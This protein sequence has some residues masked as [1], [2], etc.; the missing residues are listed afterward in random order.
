[1]AQRVEVV[2]YRPEWERLYQTESG[3]LRDILQGQLISVHHIG[4]TAVPGLAAKPVI[5]ILA[6]VKEI[7]A[8]DAYS[9]AFEAEGYECMGE[10]GI[11]GRRYFRKGGD[12]RTHQIHMFAQGSR[13]GDPPASCRAGLPACASCRSGGVWGAENPVSRTVPA[14]Y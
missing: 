9:A 14:R 11:P 12:W 6:V 3:I 2:G 13:E 5:D 4:S 10:F 7:G 1:M 8:V